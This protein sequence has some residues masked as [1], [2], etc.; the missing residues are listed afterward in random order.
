[1]GA[2]FDIIFF[3]LYQH[4]CGSCFGKIFCIP[5]GRWFLDTKQT[6]GGQH[7]V[8]AGGKQKNFRV[9]KRTLFF[10]ST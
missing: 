8:F 10:L 3:Q 5:L 7:L 1:M 4:F 6:R 2:H 9:C